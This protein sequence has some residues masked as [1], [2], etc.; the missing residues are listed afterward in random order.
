MPFG[1]ISHFV[2]WIARYSLEDS[3]LF[4]IENLKQI[5]NYIQKE[6]SKRKKLKLDKLLIKF[7][8]KLHSNKPIDF[9]IPLTNSKENLFN[10]IFFT[11]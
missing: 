1:H 7:I 5:K 10:L 9:M 4:N 2:G 8:N 6:T 11:L 3:Y